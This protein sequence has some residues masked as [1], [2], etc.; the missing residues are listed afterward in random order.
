MGAIFP[1]LTVA[2]KQ[3]VFIPF[4]VATAC[5]L[6]FM[7]FYLPETKNKPVNVTASLFEDSE[8]LRTWVGLIDPVKT[9]DCA[10]E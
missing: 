2:L 5:M 8:G 9:G 1:H 4:I 3:Y 7:F 10:I 6:C